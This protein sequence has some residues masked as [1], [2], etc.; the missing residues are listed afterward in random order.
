MTIKSKKTTIKELGLN[1]E[2]EMIFRSA[3][4]IAK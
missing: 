1:A 3:L 4:Y 2:Q